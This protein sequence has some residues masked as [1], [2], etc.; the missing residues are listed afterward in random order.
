MPTHNLIG[1]INPQSLLHSD[2]LILSLALMYIVI[3]SQYYSLIHLPHQYLSCWCLL[4]LQWG[5]A[6]Y[7]HG[8]LQQHSVGE[9][10]DGEK[11]P[12][13]NMLH[14]EYP[15]SLVC[16]QV[17]ECSQTD[18]HCRVYTLIGNGA[19][20]EWFCLPDF[21]MLISNMWQPSI[22]REDYS[23]TYFDPITMFEALYPCKLRGLI[24]YSR[25]HTAYT[26]P[27]LNGSS[28]VYNFKHGDVIE[29]CNGI[30]LVST[31]DCH[32]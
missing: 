22:E 23:I 28:T 2:S 4:Q 7:Q 16:T 24:R 29:I 9:S 31:W 20:K 14:H 12:N 13:L 15:V 6:R 32:M 1:S 19:A 25:I 18:A 5:I 26:T 11:E 30:S 8:L 3:Q 17:L 27:I 21:H 10:P